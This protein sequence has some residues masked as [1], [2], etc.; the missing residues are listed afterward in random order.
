MTLIS[1]LNTML[2]ITTSIDNNIFTNRS[3]SINKSMMH[4]NRPFSQ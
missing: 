2:N 1:Y 4:H 3:P